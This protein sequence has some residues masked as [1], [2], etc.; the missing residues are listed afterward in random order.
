MLYTALTSRCGLGVADQWES[1]V[2]PVGTASCTP[3][4]ILCSIQVVECT[5]TPVLPKHS[6]IK[7][8]HLRLQ[9]ASFQFDCRPKF[10]LLFFARNENT[11]IAKMTVFHCLLVLF[12]FVL[13]RPR[14]VDASELSRPEDWTGWGGNIHNNRWASRNKFIS[15]SN[16]LS[17]VN[18]CTLEFPI[19]VSATPV[20]SKDIVYFPTWEG[21]F[22]ALNYKSCT[23]LWTINV[24]SII[25]DFATPNPFQLQN[26]RAVSRTSPQL[27]G[28]VLF[29][30][31]MHALVVALNKN[32]GNLLNVVQINNHPLAI[33][34]MSL[35]FFSGKLFVGTSSVEENVTLFP[36]YK[37][38]SFVGNFVAV[39]FKAPTRKVKILWSV[40]SISKPRQSEG[41]AGAAVWGSQPSIDEKKGL[42]FVGTGNAYSASNVTATCQHSAVP[43]QIPYELNMGNC[44][45]RDVWQDSVLAIEFGTGRVK[46]VQQR[47][48]VDIFTAACG[49][50]GFG[51]Q[52]PELCPGVPG[53]DPDFGMAPTLVPGIEPR[54]EDKLVIGRK[55][56]DIYSLSTRDGHVMWAT[57]TSPK[58]I[59]GGLSWGI[60]V[61]DNR[62]YFTAINADYKT[63][64]L[65]PS[66]QTVN[67][68]AY[69]AVSL[70]DGRILRETPVPRNG[71]SL[72]P[73]RVV[74]NLV[75]VART[76]QDPNGTASYD[77]S[78]GGLVALNKATGQVIVDKELSTNFHGGIAVQGK[79]VL[80]GT[81][82]SGFG[83][84]ALVPS[85]F[86]SMMVA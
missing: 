17:L 85:V 57:S 75:L 48:G 26:V 18:H 78:Q 84:P 51:P 67:R 6:M 74:A 15:S 25:Y 5:R 20:I 60:A 9:E 42:V 27:D 3:V 82:Y 32:T 46:W 11:A 13:A 73:P 63:W 61:D 59:T 43:P 53:P 31:L 68:S 71:I 4:N 2:S 55:N 45:P 41:W 24:T 49:Y 50:P 7:N 10:L 54:G 83:A 65:Q 66:G 16:I 36:G 56:G 29:G 70:V 33:I 1:T 40:S 77:Q 86:H 28:D 8:I 37:C 35:T 52:N 38:C 44:L 72:G 14:C 79:Y 22:V 23:I 19:G 12:A 80:F 21:S 81:G 69:R 62:A 76:G 47:P 64:Q 30:T 58:G 39:S 34:T